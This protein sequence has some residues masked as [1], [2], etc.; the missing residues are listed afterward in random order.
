MVRFPC[1]SNGVP[2]RYNLL[3]DT[4]E[5]QRKELD[6]LRKKN[7][8]FS[9]SLVS[10]QQRIEQLSHEL[11]NAREDAKRL[12]VLV[13]NLRAEKEIISASESRLIS[14]NQQLR[15]E[16]MQQ[17]SLLDNFQSLLHAKEK[18]QNDLKQ[19][20]VEELESIQREWYVTVYAL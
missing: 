10:H 18:G 16:R 4:T 9:T 11:S 1:C 13:A 6:T 2:E 20:L 7:L 12:E 17:Q 5:M 19:R 8:E 14:E 3:V 15:K